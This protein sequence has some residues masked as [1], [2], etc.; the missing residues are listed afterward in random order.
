[1]MKKLPSLVLTILASS[2]IS[3]PAEA[4]VLGNIDVQKACKNQ[5]LLFPSIKARLVGSNA[6][7]WK[8]SVYDAFN[9]IPILNFSVD[10]TK[11]CKVQYKNSKAFGETT[12]WRS[13]YSWRCRV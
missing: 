6:Y 5:Y 4:G 13:P 11:A 7:S 8:C 10:M 2:L 12:N 1:M 9:L 3:L